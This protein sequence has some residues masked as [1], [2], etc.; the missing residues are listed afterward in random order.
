MAKTKS[1]WLR[2][3]IRSRVSSTSYHRPVFLPELGGYDQR[4]A[5]LLAVHPVHLVA[6]DRGDLFDDAPAEWQIAV[7]ARRNRPG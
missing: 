7:D 3:V 6:K 1:R 5:D 4:H 2:S